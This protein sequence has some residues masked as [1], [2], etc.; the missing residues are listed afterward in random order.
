MK[1]NS[2]MQMMS[3]A[4]LFFN[5]GELNNSRLIVEKILAQQHRNMDALEILGVI[6]AI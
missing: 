4:R 3:E 2:I 1:N 6:S 5:K